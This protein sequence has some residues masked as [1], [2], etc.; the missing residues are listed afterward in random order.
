MKLRNYPMARKV[1]AAKPKPAS[2]VSSRTKKTASKKKQVK[3]PASAKGG[4]KAAKKEKDANTLLAEAVVKGISDKKGQ[5][6]TWLDLREL[7]G[8]V[9][10]HFIIC[11][12]TSSTQIDALSRS[13][14]EVVKEET[15]QKPWHS[16]GKQNAQWILIDYVSVVVHI[17]Q[18]EVREFYNL[19]GLWADAK[20]V[21]EEN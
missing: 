18:S 13:V 15:G 7:D 6:I 4:N 17:F 19:E 2:K 1:K 16:E 5:K 9:C 11:E 10:E 20:V 21:L 14:E 8:A 3:A 12:G